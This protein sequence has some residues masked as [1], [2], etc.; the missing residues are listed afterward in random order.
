VSTAGATLDFRVSITDAPGKNAYPIATFT[1]LLLPANKGDPQTRTARY[2]LL[3][4][5]PTSGQKQ[6]AGLGYAPLPPRVSN[7]E[8]RILETLK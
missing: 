6:C 7:E 1:W 3:R 4:W 5:M 8:L 2:D